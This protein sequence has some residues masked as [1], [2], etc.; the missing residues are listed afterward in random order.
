M[1]VSV[2][3]CVFIYLRKNIVASLI[4]ANVPK[5]QIG[6]YTNIQTRCVSVCT[7]AATKMKDIIQ[8]TW[9]DEKEKNRERARHI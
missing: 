3:V 5:Q 4:F 1:F 2:C 6:S 8:I 7:Y 9:A